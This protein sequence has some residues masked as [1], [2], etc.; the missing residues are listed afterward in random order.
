MTGQH[1][2]G[3]T[4]RGPHRRRGEAPFG[5]IAA[6]KHKFPPAHRSAVQFSGIIQAEQ[7]AVP[8]AAGSKFGQHR[9]KM[10][11]HALHAPGC[12]QFWKQPYDHA[13]SLPTA[14]PLG[15]PI[16]FASSPK[17]KSGPHVS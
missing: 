4:P 2:L 7:A 14:A 8:P 17:A 15:K 3:T 12:I 16:S 11:P 9:R 13:L 5:S 1:K 6:R 10:T